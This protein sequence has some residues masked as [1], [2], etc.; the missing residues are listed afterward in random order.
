M[1]NFVREMLY[2]ACLQP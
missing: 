2:F 1:I